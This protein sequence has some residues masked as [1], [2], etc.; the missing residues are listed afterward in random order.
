MT[1]ASNIIAE[2]CRRFGIGLDELRG[3]VSNQ[4]LVRIRKIIA[5]RLRAETNLS[6]PQIGRKL[7]RDHTTIMHYLGAT[8]AG[9]AVMA[10]GKAGRWIVPVHGAHAT[11][12]GR[13][14]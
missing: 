9:A 5:Q 7:N 3:R 10:K 12:Y 2:E 14:R 1:P 6:L 13:A 4:Q 8:K 11:D